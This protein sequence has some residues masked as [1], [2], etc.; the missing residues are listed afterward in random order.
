MRVRRRRSG[1]GFSLVEALV[2]LSVGAMALALMGGAGWGLRL[3]SPPAAERSGPEAVLAA[4]RVLRDAAFG[5]ARDTA[6]RRALMAGDAA[7]LHVV[8]REAASFGG[9]LT[10]LSI[11]P[12]EGGGWRLTAGRAAG[13]NDI[14]L[15]P[16]APDGTLLLEGRGTATFAYLLADPVTRRTEWAAELPFSAPLPLAF[17]LDVDGTR[18]LTAQLPATADPLCL[19]RTGLSA[20]ED[21]SCVAR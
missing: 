16:Q 2:A 4:R 18:V 14:R 7:D 13:V 1:R 20:L 9:R 5:A 21:R 8:T 12:R 17:A 6:G 11:R 15:A 3:A 19:A 10:V